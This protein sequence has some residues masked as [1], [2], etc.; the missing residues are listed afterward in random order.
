[1]ALA[2]VYTKDTVLNA[3]TG[4]VH[5]NVLEL[6]ITLQVFD[7]KTDEEHRLKNFCGSVAESV[8]S[9]SNVM[10]VRFYAEKTGISSAFVS[11][12]TSMRVLESNEVC[13]AEV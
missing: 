2:Y 13:D 12:F 11:V 7:E 8:T 10:Y 6:K 5:Y 4:R 3:R 1:M 9:S